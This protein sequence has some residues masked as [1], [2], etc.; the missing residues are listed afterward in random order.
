MSCSLKRT[1]CVDVGKA[2][3]KRAV[4]KQEK[5]ENKRKESSCCQ[6]CVIDKTEIC[7]SYYF[8]PMYQ[9]LNIR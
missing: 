3:A 9:L 4:N 5:N 1:C 2:L 7:Q 8:I 6:Q